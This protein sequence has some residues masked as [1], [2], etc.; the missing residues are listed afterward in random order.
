MVRNA[1]TGLA[2]RLP[3]GTALLDAPVMGSVGLVAVGGLYIFAGGAEALVARHRRLLSAVGTVTH[4]GPVGAGTAAKLVA[5]AALF[6]VLGVLG[7]A[8]LLAGGLGLDRDTAFRVLAATPLAAQAERRRP[9]IEQ[10]SYPARFALCLARKDADLIHAAAGASDVGLRLFEAAGPGWRRRIGPGSPG[11]TTPRSSATFCARTG[12]RTGRLIDRV[13][14]GAP[15]P[16]RRVCATWCQASRSRQSPILFG[17]TSSPS[18]PKKCAA[19][20]G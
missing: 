2:A 16:R 11:T 13:E 10:G 4:V 6:G 14:A 20:S 17:I 8:L 15:A 5:N 12:S 1:V 9:A 7:E 19:R 3:A 18:S